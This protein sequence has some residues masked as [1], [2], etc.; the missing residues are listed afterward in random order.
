LYVKDNMVA[1]AI[2]AREVMALLVQN[3]RKTVLETGAG[4]G[5]KRT[6]ECHR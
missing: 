6:D 4:F 2:T 5:E 3:L 1:I